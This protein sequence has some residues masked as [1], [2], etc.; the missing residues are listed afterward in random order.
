MDNLLCALFFFFW[1]ITALESEESFEND[2]QVARL[3]TQN[4]GIV[5]IGLLM[6][7]LLIC[8]SVSTF[9]CN[10]A[11]GE[12]LKKTIKALYIHLLFMD[13]LIQKLDEHFQ[14][15]FL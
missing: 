10:L 11:F 15:E 9:L 5:D 1:L 7:T 6:I 14:T 2:N 13:G 3:K 12:D 4:A 8:P